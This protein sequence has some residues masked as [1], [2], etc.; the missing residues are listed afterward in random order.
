MVDSSNHEYIF[1]NT[2]Y[3]VESE[4]KENDSGGYCEISAWDSSCTLSIDQV[5]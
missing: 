4:I 5:Q 2:V 1:V 3:K